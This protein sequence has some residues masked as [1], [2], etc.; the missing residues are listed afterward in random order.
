MIAVSQGG[1]RVLVRG[2]QGGERS[3][4]KIFGLLVNFGGANFYR[5]LP[6]IHPQTYK[7]RA[8]IRLTYCYVS[9]SQDIS[10]SFLPKLIIRAFIKQIIIILS[11]V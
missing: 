11:L 3:E 5:G 1:F 9:S 7:Q 6:S 10:F 8:D 4:L 2:L